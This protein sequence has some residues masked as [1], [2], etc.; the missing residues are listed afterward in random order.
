MLQR[1]KNESHDKYIRFLKL[2]KA[3][4]ILYNMTSIMS[5]Q[6]QRYLSVHDSLNYNKLL[7]RFSEEYSVLLDYFKTHYISITKINCLPTD[8]IYIKIYLETF[9]P[10]CV[11]HLESSRNWSFH[12]HQFSISAPRSYSDL[13]IDISENK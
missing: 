13:H 8:Y 1:I 10:S 7:Y 2:S 3:K 9:L 11:L 4:C 6:K 5:S 12:N